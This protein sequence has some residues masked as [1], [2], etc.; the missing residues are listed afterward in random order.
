MIKKKYFIGSISVM[1]LVLIALIMKISSTNQVIGIQSTLINSLEKELLRSVDLNDELS[2][3]IKI[4]DSILNSHKLLYDELESKTQ[5]LEDNLSHYEV[6][7]YY[8]R[9]SSPLGKDATTILETDLLS[10]KDTIKLYE[11]SPW[12]MYFTDVRVL[13]N[14]LAIGYFEDGHATGYG[15]YEYS[16]NEKN[17]IVWQ[18]IYERMT[19]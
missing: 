8:D 17:Q 3:N 18:V 9:I 15:I 7:D 2:D 6:F 13:S 11:D 16:I 4:Y 5:I 12:D 19:H 1:L 10:N 14:S